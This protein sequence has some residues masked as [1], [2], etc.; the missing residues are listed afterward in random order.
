MA[1][2]MWAL[3]TIEEYVQYLWQEWNRQCDKSGKAPGSIDDGFREDVM[4]IMRKAE[5]DGIIATIL[6]P[7]G[8]IRVL[9]TTK[10]G[11]EWL[12]TNEPVCRLNFSQHERGD[13]RHKVT[14]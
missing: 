4:E 8:Q 11:D 1:K 7:D 13:H 9:R 10:C 2:D 3:P 6:G 12:N 5:R 14:L